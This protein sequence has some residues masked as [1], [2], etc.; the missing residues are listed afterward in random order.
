MI[1]LKSNKIEKKYDKKIEK[2]E[3][4]RAQ[5]ILERNGSVWFCP[6]CEQELTFSHSKIEDKTLEEGQMNIRCNRC[7]Q[8]SIWADYGVIYFCPILLE[9][10]VK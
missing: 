3:K 6:H 1:K 9:K 5:E 8:V 7:K 2:L 10:D 4:K